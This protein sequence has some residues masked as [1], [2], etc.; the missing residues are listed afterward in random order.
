MV[1]FG[2]EPETFEMR[3]WMLPDCSQYWIIQL[4]CKQMGFLLVLLEFPFNAKENQ[5]E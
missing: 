4:M 3:I 2:F 1:S 5:M